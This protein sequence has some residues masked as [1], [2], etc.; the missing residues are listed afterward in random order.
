MMC[1]S[2]CNL[3]II[4]FAQKKLI[5]IGL[6]NIR[7]HRMTDRVDLTVTPEAK[8]EEFLSYLAIQRG[9]KSDANAPLKTLK[10]RWC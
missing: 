10:S 7:L 3:I 9:E 2:L 4:P 8:I 5:Q 1:D 6:D